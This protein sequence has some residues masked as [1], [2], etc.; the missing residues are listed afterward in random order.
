[1]RA[2]PF[3]VLATLPAAV[4]WA[5]TDEQRAYLAMAATIYTAHVVCP[6]GLDPDPTTTVAMLGVAGGVEPDDV[7]PGGRFH[8]LFQEQVLALAHEIKGKPPAASCATLAE[9]YP[10]WIRPSVR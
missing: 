4:C 6:G 5:Q 7:A 9:K 10:K 3:L 8:A 1:M 2:L